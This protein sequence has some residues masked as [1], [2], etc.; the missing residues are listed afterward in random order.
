MAILAGR[1]FLFSIYLLFTFA[2]AVSPLIALGN[3]RARKS[4]ESP[5]WVGKTWCGRGLLCVDEEL[6]MSAVAARG[7]C[8]VTASGI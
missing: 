4:V 8:L 3:F 2:P 5:E 1:V 6:E 7:L